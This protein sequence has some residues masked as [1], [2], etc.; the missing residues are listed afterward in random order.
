MSFCVQS[1]S[2]GLFLRAG[3]DPHSE[4]L[5]WSVFPLI[6]DFSAVMR[7]VQPVCLPTCLY[8]FLSFFLYY[9]QA[10]VALCFHRS[11][12]WLA[13]KF[14]FAYCLCTDMSLFFPSDTAAVKLCNF[15]LNTLKSAESHRINLST[16]EL[17]HPLRSLDQ[18]ILARP[19]PPPLHKHNM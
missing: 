16:S 12:P 18:C 15:P 14:T 8:G 13:A 3:N 4:S 2:C 5:L 9:W 11:N 7:I 10:F 6:N 1:C 19:H 17:L